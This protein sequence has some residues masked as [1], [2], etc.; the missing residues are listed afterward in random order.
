MCSIAW[1]KTLAQLTKSS[2]SEN[3]FSCVL[4]VLIEDSN[5]TYLAFFSPCS[6]APGLM[7]VAKMPPPSDLL[8]PHQTLLRSRIASPAERKNLRRD[9]PLIHSTNISC[10]EEKSLLHKI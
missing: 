3:E 8:L 5:N 4:I 6:V 1:N 2:P 7:V 10:G 9:Y